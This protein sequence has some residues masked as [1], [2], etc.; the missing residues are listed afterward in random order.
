MGSFTAVDIICAVILLG[1]AAFSFM[2]GFVHQV[3]AIGAWVGAVLGAMH[4]YPI[5]QPFVRERMDSDLGANLAT[6]IGLFLV[7]LLILSILTKAI[8][9]RV[10][11][12]ALNSVDSSLGVV[13]GLI[14]G[15]ALLSA[16]Y[17]GVTWM[18]GTD[19]PPPD[20][21]AKARTRPWLERGADLLRGFVPSQFGG[22]EAKAREIKSD[23][24]D[25]IEA[26]KTFRKYVAP[27][28]AGQPAS[29]KDGDKDSQAKP[30]KGYDKESRGQLDRLIQNNQ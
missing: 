9:D 16:A 21:L 22:A 23:A 1:F 3:L 30:A 11:R 20:W 19:Q 29:Q 18:A 15:A 14:M 8:S 25:L 5:V 28:P 13:F 7:A 2:R 4:G 24:K 6:G 17:L 10:R 26:E 27:Q 12:S